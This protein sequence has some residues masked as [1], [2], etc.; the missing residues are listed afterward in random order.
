MAS[1]TRHTCPAFRTRL[2]HTFGERQ[3]E[4]PNVCRFESKFDTHPHKA[5]AC[6]KIIIAVLPEFSE[7]LHPN[8]V[9]LAIWS[10]V[11]TPRTRELEHVLFD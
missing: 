2:F 7:I 4:M 3:L 11:N 9:L 8:L 1:N 5:L 10:A 6:P